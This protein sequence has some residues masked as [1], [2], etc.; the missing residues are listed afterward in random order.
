[1]LKTKNY[2]IYGTNQHFLQLEGNRLLLFA[3]NNILQR[4]CNYEHELIHNGKLMLENLG[5]KELLRLRSSLYIEE[6]KDKFI[7]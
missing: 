1:M 3:P 5:F 4:M 7:S 6:Y 2:I